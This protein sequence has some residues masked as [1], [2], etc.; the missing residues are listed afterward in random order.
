MNIADGRFSPFCGKIAIFAKKGG[1]IHMAKSLSQKPVCVGSVIV[2]IEQHISFGEY[3]EKKESMM[4][5]LFVIDDINRKIDRNDPDITHSISITRANGTGDKYLLAGEAEGKEIR[6]RTDQQAKK[7]EYPKKE[8]EQVDLIS[9]A[10]TDITLNDKEI[11]YVELKR[12]IEENQRKY[13]ELAKELREARLSDDEAGFLQKK[14]IEKTEGMQAL[15]WDTHMK[16]KEISDLEINS[17]ETNYPDFVG[18]RPGMIIYTDDKSPWL[19]LEKNPASAEKILNESCATGK[20]EDAFVCMSL[21]GAERLVFTSQNHQIGKDTSIAIS[22]HTGAIKEDIW[23]VMVKNMSVDKLSE[24]R[25]EIMKASAKNPHLCEAVKECTLSLRKQL[26]ARVLSAGIGP[27][28]INVFNCNELKS[29]AM[30]RNTAELIRRY[31]QISEDLKEIRS[32]TDRIIK[33]YGLD[34]DY[35]PGSIANEAIKESS[36]PIVPKE[37]LERTS[38]LSALLNRA[39]TGATKQK[40]KGSKSPLGKGILKG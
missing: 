35:G 33:T 14:I 21:K 16:L 24:E 17:P 38:N 7:I 39:A 37:K 25:L 26:E 9:Y 29:K 3:N 12:D 20:H 15:N 40:A 32:I 11:K 36:Q 34:K 1:K 19:V 8:I 28:E 31:P 22:S 23:R 27:D 6:I 2:G 10:V 13:M 18:V 5:E 4:K 30:D